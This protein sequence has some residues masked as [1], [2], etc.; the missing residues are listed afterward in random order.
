MRYVKKRATKAPEFK[1]ILSHLKI[2][3]KEWWKCL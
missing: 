1:F 3:I 2:K